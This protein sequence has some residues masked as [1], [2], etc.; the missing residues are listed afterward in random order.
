ME[1]NYKMLYTFLIMILM[2]YPLIFYFEG[3]KLFTV[4]SILLFLGGII[5]ALTSILF[6]IWL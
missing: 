6:I 2:G 1:L 3:N 5:G 4:T